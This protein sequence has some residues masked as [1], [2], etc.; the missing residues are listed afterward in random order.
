MSSGTQ[1]IRQNYAKN[2]GWLATVP[3]DQG[4]TFYITNWKQMKTLTHS[5]HS[6]STMMQTD[7]SIP[8]YNSITF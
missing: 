7:P 3:M 1:N 8:H 5:T 2:I 4:A 6:P